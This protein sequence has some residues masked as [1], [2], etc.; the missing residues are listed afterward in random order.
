MR[1]LFVGADTDGILEEA[2]EK[3][4]EIGKKVVS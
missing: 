1:I 2:F 4:D 3:I